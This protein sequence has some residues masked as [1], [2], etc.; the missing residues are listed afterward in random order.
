ML[1]PMGVARVAVIGGCG[2]VGLP[3]ALCFVQA[4]LNVDVID[5]DDTAVESVNSGVMPFHETGADHLLNWA[6]GTGRLRASTDPSSLPEA[7]AVVLVVGTPV[8]ESLTPDPQSIIAVLE[9]YLPLLRDDQLLVL[10]STVYPGVTRRVEVFLEDA[11]WRGDVAFCPERILEGK[12][13]DEI[14]RLPQIIGARKSSSLGRATE[15]F[16]RLGVRCLEASPEEA[17]LAKLFT[18]V[19]RYV[20]F[21]AANE[22]WQVANEAQEDFARIRWLMS[23]D[24]PR[25]AD[26]PGAGYAAGPCLYKDTMQVSTFMSGSLPVALGAAAANE[27]L[28]L[29][30]VNQLARKYDLAHMTVAILGMA[31]KADSD[32]RRASLSYKLKRIL[33]FHAKRVLTSDPYVK[34]DDDLVSQE[35]ALAQADLVIIGAPHATYANL[36]ISVPIADVWNLLKRGST[37]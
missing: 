10:R 28:P 36:D 34:D 1:A 2:H 16:S 8:D 33:K 24:Y 27:G 32:D 7:E 25:A 3:L 22:F 31:F 14:P 30:V 13:L 26:V 12:A 15:L 11:G 4:G 29:Y 18:N 20:K 9:S 37:V 23:T 6:L 21:A 35:E 19:W 17:E 5:I